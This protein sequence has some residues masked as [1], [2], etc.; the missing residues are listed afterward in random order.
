MN[1][2]DSPTTASQSVPLTRLEQQVQQLQEEI[3]QLRQENEQLR[4]QKER[5]FSIEIVNQQQKITQQQTQALEKANPELWQ[6][7]RLLEITAI[8]ASALLTIE[9]FDEAVKAALQTIGKG[10]ETDRVGVIENFTLPSKELPGWRVLYEWNSPYTIAQISDLNTSQGCYEE[11]RDWHDL[12]CQG[13]PVSCQIEQMPEPF[14][15]KQAAIGVKAFYLVPIFVEGKWWGVLGLDDCREAKH[16]TLAELAVLKI[17]AN[18]I[19]SAIQR[20][21]TQKAMLQ[22]EQARSAGL[23]KANEVLRRT[24]SKLVGQEDLDRF[25]ESVIF[26]VAQE[27]EAVNN[28]VF[29]Y[30]SQTNTLLMHS[31]IQ[32]GQV[33]NLE[34]DPRFELWRTPVPAD[35]NEGWK[36]TQTRGYVWHSLES[37]AM[38]GGEIWDIS[39]PWHRMM[40][41]RFVL[42]VLLQ[43]GDEP[44]GFM[45]LCFCEQMHLFAER[46]ELVQT[47]A[48]QAALAIQLTRLA[49]EAKQAAI[50]ED[51]N[52]MARE[53]HDTLAQSF[54]GIL[55]Q[56]QAATL[57]LID[58]PEQVIVHLKRAS[59]LTREG[60]A[61]ARRSVSLLLQEDTAYSDLLSSLHQ[62]VEQMG[63]NTDVPISINV[64]G[65][66]YPL[67]PEVGMH[68]FRM[69]QESLNNALRH[70]D[71]STIQIN[72]S[73]MVQESLNNALRHA[74]PSTIQINL[75]YATQKVSLCIQDNG[76][77]FD[78]EQP[79]NGFGL[80]GMQQRADLLNA[81]L[82]INSQIG[83]GTEV[84]ITALAPLS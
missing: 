1:S 36:Q 62:L 45:E 18:C 46:I 32:E 7:D 69:V 42:S 29:L 15:G 63:C 79:T 72:L 48:H 66:P 75:S 3:A 27:T 70:A 54:A 71:P 14:R 30:N 16:R 77:G 73:Y 11:I 8:A 13:Q 24:A 55:M 37:S 19:G 6:P 84:H 50:L 26:E 40:G 61:E 83:T 17:A 12:F 39:V 68:L 58:D 25:L 64:E 20:D 49:E 74:D 60:L 78:L 28:S 57:N 33:I 43:V 2:S 38:T 4:Q 10:L 51:R 5:E 52:C 81:Q 31:A 34:T 59:N 56:L 9:N 65:T 67:N 23:A 22:A 35:I 21:R 53:I 47:L 76:R 80:K 82:Q 41:H 44:L